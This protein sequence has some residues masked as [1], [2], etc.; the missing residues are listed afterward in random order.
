MGAHVSQRL[1]GKY[2]SASPRFP[3]APEDR[4]PVWTTIPA[5]K[6]PASTTSGTVIEFPA[7]IRWILVES[8]GGVSLLFTDTDSHEAAVISGMMFYLPNRKVRIRANGTAPT[9][10][11]KLL[12]LS[13]ED[14]EIMAPSAEA[15]ATAVPPVVPATVTTTVGFNGKNYNGVA[16]DPQIVPGTGPR[17]VQIGLDTGTPPGPNEVGTVFCLASTAALAQAGSGII[18]LPGGDFT[19]PG[20]LAQLCEI[21]NQG[22]SNNWKAT[23][24]Y[25]S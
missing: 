10:V 3:L 17:V 5:A 22:N 8:S 20:G 12:G 1:D 16:Y 18:M 7:W 9:S 19:W 15:G 14:A 25:T 24:A 11:V 13:H 4:A 6:I 2:G 23:V 21:H